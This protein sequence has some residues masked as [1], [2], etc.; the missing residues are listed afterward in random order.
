VK[1]VYE[2]KASGYRRFFSDRDLADRFKDGLVRAF[3]RQF[4]AGTYEVITECHALD[5]ELVE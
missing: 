1:L 5:L 4:G 3:T 2:V